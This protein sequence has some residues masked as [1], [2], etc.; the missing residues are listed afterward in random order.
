MSHYFAKR[1]V[2]GDLNFIFF[3]LDSSNLGSE[4]LGQIH[5]GVWK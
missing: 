3:P 1:R 4:I 2:V 5:V